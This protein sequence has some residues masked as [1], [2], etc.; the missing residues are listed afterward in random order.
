MKLFNFLSV[1]IPF[2][3][4]N[5]NAYSTSERTSKIGGEE[6]ILLYK[7]LKTTPNAVKENKGATSTLK[8]QTA[9]GEVYCVVYS[10]PSEH[11]ARIIY[12]EC[13]IQSKTGH[14]LN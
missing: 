10:D 8:V 7:A 3:C 12:G 1:V 11:G 13:D 6:A 2:L 4:L 5:A 9:S 14:L